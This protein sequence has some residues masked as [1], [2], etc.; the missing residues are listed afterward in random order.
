MFAYLISKLLCNI[1]QSFRDVRAEKSAS[2]ERTKTSFGSVETLSETY[3]ESLLK[4]L[5][6][7]IIF[8]VFIVIFPPEISLVISLHDWFTLGALAADKYCIHNAL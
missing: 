3:L 7:K 8:Y 4:L 5:V 6:R 2:L 1:Y